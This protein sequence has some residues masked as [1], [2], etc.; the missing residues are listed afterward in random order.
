MTERELFEQ[1]IPQ[2]AE[3]IVEARKMSAAEY[4]TWKDMVLSGINVK[5]TDFMNKVFIVIEK[6]LPALKL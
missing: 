4:C 3:I 1:C 6:H 5:A 2:I